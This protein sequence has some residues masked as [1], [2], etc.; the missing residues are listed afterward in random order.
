M[1]Q[2]FKVPKKFIQKRLFSCL[3]AG[4]LGMCFSFFAL[5][6]LVS[7]GVPFWI[8]LVSIS[9]AG[10]IF[11][12]MCY[13]LI[14][15]HF[16]NKKLTLN[17]DCFVIQFYGYESKV[18][19][20][21]IKKMLLHESK[22]FKGI[23]LETDSGKR[24]HLCQFENMDEIASVVKSRL[25]DDV[26]IDTAKEKSSVALMYIAIVL[27]L[28]GGPFKFIAFSVL[29]LKVKVFTRYNPKFKTGELWFGYIFLVMGVVNLISKFIGGGFIK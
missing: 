4:F 26:V 16:K 12:F 2:E 22:A 6:L 17:E 18:L 10:I 27:V 14:S 23:S 15:K 29:A 8:V 20:A 21:D 28:F 19:Y 9:G 25:A 3:L 13:F 24:Y 11:L 1:Q 7:N 5:M